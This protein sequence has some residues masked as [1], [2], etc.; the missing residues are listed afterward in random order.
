MH[1]FFGPVGD[2]NFSGT[3]ELGWDF[4][5]DPLLASGEAASFYIPLITDPAVAGTWYAGLQHVWRTQDNAGSQSHLDSE[6]NEF[7]PLSQFD[8]NGDCGDWVAIG[9][10]LSSAS[11]GGKAPGQYIVATSRAPSDNGTLWAGLR[12][13]RVFVT[14]NANNPSPAA[15]TFHR[16]D[17]AAQPTRFV[18]GISIDA[19]NP[20]HAFI[21]YSGYNAYATAAG[22]A[23]GHIFEVTYNPVTHVATWSG[24]LAGGDP[25]TGGLGDQPITGI[26]VD[27]NKGDVFVSTDFGVFV[28][29]SGNTTWQPAARGLP[30][31]AVFGLTIDLNARV[32]YAATHGRG[33]WRLDLS[34]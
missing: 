26:A 19:S 14:S 8:P 29:K 16:I 13:G 7:L 24:D 33:A 22:T 3:K 9:Q 34:P 21:S 1:T 2:V 32:L 5:T 30:P 27:W 20:N 31:V 11:F 23:T 4:M 25:S 28:R 15:V 17:T 18:S 12:R 6:C 10:D